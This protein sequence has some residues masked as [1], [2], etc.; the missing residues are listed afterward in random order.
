M[1]RSA[2]ASALLF[3]LMPLTARAATRPV[4]EPI[5]SAVSAAESP[6]R[7]LGWL[8]GGTW[9]AE[10]KAA[11]GGVVVVRLRCRWAD[12]GHA[13]LFRVGFVGDGGD[14]T[15]QYDGMFV[16]HPGRNKLT[17]WQVDRKGEVAEGEVTGSGDEFDQAV[18]VSHPD[19]SVHFLK[20]RY[21]REKRD[22]FRFQAFFR[23]SETAAW[24]D[25]LDVVYRR[26]PAGKR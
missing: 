24:R 8:V 17:L 1:N 20:G 22:A 5:E 3:V 4:G 21:R 25:A 2:A 19:G 23:T 18:R 26:L 9:V 13:I 14:E 7:K 10:E 11:D 15:P 12:T 16:W 6:L